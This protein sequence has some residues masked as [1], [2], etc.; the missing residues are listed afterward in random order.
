MTWIVLSMLAFQPP[1]FEVASLKPT[2]HRAR[3]V[4]AVRTSPG[5]RVSIEGSPLEHL[6]EVALDVQRF[7]VTAAR[8]GC[9]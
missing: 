3:A 8:I 7:Q 4:G 1:A 6:V 2:A 5:G 9:T